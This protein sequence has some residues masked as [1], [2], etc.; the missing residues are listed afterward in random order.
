MPILIYIKRFFKSLGIVRSV[1]VL[2][3]DVICI[4]CATLFALLLRSDF[5]IF[6]KTSFSVSEYIYIPLIFIVLRII[7]SLIFKTYKSVVRYT[8]TTDIF[9]ILLSNIA[10][11]AAIVAINLI[12]YA[13]GRHFIVPHSVVVMEFTITT[14]IMVF[15]RLTFKVLYLETINPA[16]KK[17]DVVIVGAGASGVITKRALDR[18]VRTK[19]NV[20]AFFDKDPNKIGKKIENATVYNAQTM[21]DFLEHHN[22]NFLIVAIQNMP[23]SQLNE[24]TE[25][26]LQHNAKVLVVPPVKRWINGELSFKQIKKVK[27]E[28]LLE[29]GEIV[30]DTH[31]I[32]KDLCGKVILIT[33]AAGSIGSEIVR[34]VMKYQYKRLIL[35]DNAE[36]PVF[37]LR[38]EC[39]ATN[40]LRDI[41]IQIVDIRDVVKMEEIISQE[42]PDLIY[43]AAAYKHVPMMEENPSASLKNNVQGTKILADLAVKYGVKKFVMVSTDKAV[44][45]T[46]VMGCSKRIA[47]IYVQS[48]NFEQDTTKFITT[49]FG[50]VLGT[51]GSVI[52]IFKQQIENGGPVTV[53]DREITRFFMT[54]PEACQ[55]VIN[56]GA[57]GNGGEI[58]IFDMGQPVRIYDLAVK[59][60]RL[61][62]LTLGKDIQITFTGLRPGEKLYEEL[63]ANKENTTETPNPK[64]MIAKV[65]TYDYKE[66]SKEIDELIALKDN[67]DFAIVKKMKDIVPEY[68]SKNSVFEA[69]NQ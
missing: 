58:F 12:T 23:P 36:T 16:R 5:M 68:I 66:V 46:N 44:N 55:L 62:G 67:T 50:N 11:S 39:Y 59:M 52:P 4:L 2:L 26:G 40:G 54:I 38:N 3:A 29:R 51:N 24:I 1:W 10:G 47:E 56:A 63:L 15:Y 8:N 65:R 21:A 57:M 45:P 18:D 30:L 49:R 37:Y 22:I 61:S 42:K 27:I 9:R 13:I 34:Q 25:I 64:I 7:F 48:L 31:L 17:R 32:T 41:D 69:L 28:D 19:Y 35:V 20:L 33:G 6:S 53:T 14:L 60:I 43:H